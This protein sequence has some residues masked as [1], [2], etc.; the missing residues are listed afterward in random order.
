MNIL[1]KRVLFAVLMLGAVASSVFAGERIFPQ[2]KMVSQKSDENRHYLLPLGR[3]KPD[4]A[5]GRDLPSEYK[6]L[7]GIFQ[8][9]VWELTGNQTIAESK[10]LVEA[11]IES[12]KYLSVSRETFG[13]LAFHCSMVLD[14]A[15][16]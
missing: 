7:D 13:R 1:G 2:A 5:L 11:Y 3:V 15:P 14:V 10:A 8:S 16:Q 4:R 12:A 6:R 9:E